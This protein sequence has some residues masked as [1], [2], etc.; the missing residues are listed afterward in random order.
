MASPAT[1]RNKFV[2]PTAPPLLTE[3]TE[4]WEDAPP[5]EYDINSSIPL[6]RQQLET[7][8]VRLEPLIV[9]SPPNSLKTRLISLKPSLHGKALAEAFM[10]PPSQEQAHGDFSFY[11]FPNGKPLRGFNL[12]QVHIEA[13]SRVC[14][15]ETSKET[16][17]YIE[18]LRR[19]SNVL[20]FAIIDKATESLAGIVA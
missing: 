5:T 11:P 2:P 4:L 20:P 19:R 6:P 8:K 3:D 1:Y 10:T 16:F 17:K 18:S 7:E 9:S 15:T 12:S 14:N 13:E